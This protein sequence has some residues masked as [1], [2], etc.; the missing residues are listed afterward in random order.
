[1]LQKIGVHKNVVKFLGCV[2]KSQPFMT[3]MELVANG[4]LKEYLL[5]LR[6]MWIKNKNKR[7]FFPE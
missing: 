6:E 3:I 7:R 5:K 1:M 4:D 2:T